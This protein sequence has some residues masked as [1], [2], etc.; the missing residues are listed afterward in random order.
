MFDLGW[1]ELLLITLM[2][3]IVISPKDLPQAVRAVSQFARQL[4]GLSR[5]FRSGVSELVREAELDELKRQVEKSGK[6]DHLGGLT[7]A[8]DPT[9][10]ITEDFDPR[11]FARELKQRVNPEKAPPGEIISQRAKAEGSPAVIRAADRAD[12]HEQAGARQDPT[13]E[14]EEPAPV[15]VE[16]K[17]SR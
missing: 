5:E 2:A 6:F 11:Q 16:K 17:I 9:S 12:V 10:S 13:S 4:R 1:Q 3:I 15:I 7:S 14:L 8:S